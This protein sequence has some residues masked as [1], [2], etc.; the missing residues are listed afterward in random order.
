MNPT[1]TKLVSLLRENARL[2]TSELARMLNLSR[3]TVHGRIRRLEQEGII[4][5]YTLVYGQDY[6]KSLVSAHVLIKVL[7]KLTVRTNRELHGMR[8][9]KS[10]YAI[11]GDYDLIAVVQ[12]ETTQS[13]SQILDKIGNLDGVERT[14]S[15]VILET[16][17]SR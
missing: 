4:G 6:E 2:S 5:G 16:K 13:L 3:S 10:L 8:E 12:A 14:N 11:S 17:F 15:S 1:D 7:Q 9:I